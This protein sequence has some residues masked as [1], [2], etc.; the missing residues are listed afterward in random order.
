MHLAA[1]NNNA[2]T[3]NS[4]TAYELMDL[5]LNS[6]HGQQNGQG[7]HFQTNNQKYFPC[8]NW[9]HVFFINM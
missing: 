6:S 8:I 1:L 2:A 3:A 4:N 5:P 9:R 7:A